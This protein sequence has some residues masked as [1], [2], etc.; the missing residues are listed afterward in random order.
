MKGGKGIRNKDKKRHR[1]KRMIA[2]ANSIRL[3]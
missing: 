3:H 2:T 1:F